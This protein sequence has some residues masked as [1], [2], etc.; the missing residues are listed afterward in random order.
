MRLSR[1]PRANRVGAA[2][3]SIPS[4]PHALHIAHN[5]LLATKAYLSKSC[6][7]ANHFGQRSAPLDHNNNHPSKSYEPLSSLYKPGDF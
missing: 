7:Y 3:C 1:Q 2:T 5:D 6:D 4:S